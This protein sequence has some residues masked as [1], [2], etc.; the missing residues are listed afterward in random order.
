MFSDLSGIFSKTFRMGLSG[1]LLDGSALTALR[2]FL[3]P[4]RSGTV[5][6]TS[7]CLRAL[8]DQ[9]YSGKTHFTPIRAG[10]SYGDSIVPGE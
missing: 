1:P 6:L 3:L 5:A 7:D 4:D 10:Y 2:S 8:H 9:A